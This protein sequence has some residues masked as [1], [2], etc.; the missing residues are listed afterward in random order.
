MKRTGYLYEKVID[1]DNIVAAM[2][3][4]DRRRPA[5]AMISMASRRGW[6]RFI[7]REYSPCF[8]TEKGYLWQ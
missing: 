3:E 5:Y 2:I 6:L 1:Y 4:Y 7:N 8:L